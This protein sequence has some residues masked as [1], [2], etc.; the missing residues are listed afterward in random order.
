MAPS[1]NPYGH[2][3]HEIDGAMGLMRDNMAMMAERDERLHNVSEKSSSLQGGALA[4]NRQAKRMRWQMRWQQYRISVL[5]VL[6][7]VWATTFYFVGRRYLKTFFAGSV[8]AILLLHWA[9]RVA[10]GWLAR[11]GPE[12]ERQ[13][14]GI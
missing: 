4:F 6:L 3:R 5:V 11:N 8:A 7:L 9:Q 2:A 1:D 14:L 10:L 12:D 13:L